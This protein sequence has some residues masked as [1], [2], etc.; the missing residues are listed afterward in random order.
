MLFKNRWAR[1]ACESE[2]ERHPFSAIRLS[3]CIIASK[4]AWAV[5][6][7]GQREGPEVTGEPAL[8]GPA[9][10]VGPVDNYLCEAWCARFLSRHLSA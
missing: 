8:L 6:M 9:H 5:H 3:S 1:V 4:Y 7:P 2:V 10:A